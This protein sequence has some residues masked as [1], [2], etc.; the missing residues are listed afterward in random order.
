MRSRSSLCAAMI[1]SA[2]STVALSADI[3][4]LTAGAYKPIALALAPAFEQQTGHKL[5]VAN[6]TAGALE[7]SEILAV[8]GAMLVG[9][10][11]RA[12]DVLKAKC[13]EAL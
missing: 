5:V 7:I 8:P 10:I 9:P 11:P 13:T 4:V 12:L 1:V 3:K 2:S 6:D